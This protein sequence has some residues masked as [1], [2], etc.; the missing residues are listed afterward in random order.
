MLIK[1]YMIKLLPGR[2]GRMTITSLDAF[3]TVNKIPSLDVNLEPEEYNH[4][5]E[6]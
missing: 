5:L 1:H 6:V 2:I 3:W 4:N